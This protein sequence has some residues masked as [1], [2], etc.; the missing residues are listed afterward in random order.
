MWTKITWIIYIDFGDFSEL[1]VATISALMEEFIGFL[2]FQIGEMNM[3]A[4]GWWSR[5]RWWWRLRK[6]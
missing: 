1:V 3:T 5:W 6:R 2:V 4:S